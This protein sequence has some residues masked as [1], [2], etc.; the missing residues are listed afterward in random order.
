MRK[1]RLIILILICLI[2]SS[3]II[4]QSSDKLVMSDSVVNLSLKQLNRW[5]MICAAKK[6]TEENSRLDPIIAEAIV[7]TVSERTT[8]LMIA[9]VYRDFT[10]EQF[11][12]II[13][14][15]DTEAYC[16]ISSSLVS[17]SLSQLVSSEIAKYMNSDT[18]WK[19]SI[20][21]S[22]NKPFN[23][24]VDKFLKLPNNKDLFK[25]IAQPL[26]DKQKTEV[27]DS[28]KLS[29]IQ[30]AL[31][32]NFSNYL[33]VVLAEHISQEQLQEVVDFFS[34]PYMSTI[35]GKTVPPMKPILNDVMK[36]PKAFYQK[37]T[38]ELG[39][40]IS[41]KDTSAIVREYIQLLPHMP[42]TWDELSD[43]LISFNE[44]SPNKGNIRKGTSKTSLQKHGQNIEMEEKGFFIDRELHGNGSIEIKRGSTFYQR[45]DGYFAFGNLYGKGKKQSVSVSN[46]G[47]TCNQTINGYFYQ[48]VL[49]GE[50]EYKELIEN[51]SNTTSEDVIYTF[52]RL[53]I[54]FACQVPKQS[55]TSLTIRAKGN[56]VND[57]LN[58]KA[59]ITL[60][61]GDYYKGVFMNGYFLDG[62]ARITY[63]DGNIYEGEIMSG[64][65]EGNGKLTRADGSWDE[66]TFMFGS[67][68]SGTKR[69]KRGEL[70]KIQP[71]SLR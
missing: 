62:T 24:L 25:D 7:Y 59:E 54:E 48:G 17:E 11:R 51:I 43:E 64:R 22:N 53:G 44:K 50:M 15:M 42:V 28:E 33:K 45:E 70:H 12:E 66:G 57:K 36:N 1:L 49:S 6:L 39:N 67:F 27:D 71:R 16:R 23:A 18:S 69:D 14:F 32:K 56:V 34:K 8:C 37:A 61:N 31:Q 10:D 19:S 20:V 40:L 52:S 30:K 35:L 58:G 38:K 3:V 41:V 5:D 60:S 63:I 47:W 65:Y 13:R 2:S 4:A 21:A 26:I 9:D 55:S 46:E 29:E 68:F